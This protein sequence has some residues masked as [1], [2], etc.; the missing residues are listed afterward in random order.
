MVARYVAMI[1]HTV[2]Y[3]HR[4]KEAY[5][6]FLK[7]DFWRKLSKQKREL[8]NYTCERCKR[9]TSKVQAHHKF[10]R[11]DWYDTQLQDLECLCKP[12][13]RLA[14]GLGPETDK[15]GKH[16]NHKGERYV[17][18]GNSICGRQSTYIK[19][20]PDGT[21]HEVTYFYHPLCTSNKP[22]RRQVRRMKKLQR[23]AELRRLRKKFGF[24]HDWN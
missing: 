8:A 11:D 7:S 20:D 21:R 9:K 12:C 10:Y 15:T 14:H 16:P 4:T 6:E 17:R 13:H 3:K 19:I 24:R 1:L 22:T 18:S 2:N 23:R 5:R